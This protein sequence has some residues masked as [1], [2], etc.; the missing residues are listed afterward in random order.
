MRRIRTI[1]WLA[2]AIASSPLHAQTTGSHDSDRR[3]QASA[4]PHGDTGHTTPF[5]MMTKPGAGQ[6][7][8]GFTPPA[9]AITTL[10]RKLV[11][12]S[13]QEPGV[14]CPIPSIPEP[15]PQQEKH[16]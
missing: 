16:E 15:P 3:V 11:R 10:L 4:S 8:D 5:P 6:D 2:L 1:L 14:Q 7:C 13:E 9:G 12:S